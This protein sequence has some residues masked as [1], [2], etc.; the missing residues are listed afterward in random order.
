MTRV[1]GIDLSLTGTGMCRIVTGSHPILVQTITFATK[2]ADT[3]TLGSRGDRLATIV[4]LVFGLGWHWE[5]DLVTVEGP[6]LGKPSPHTWDRAGLWW[7]VMEALRHVVPVVEIPPTTLKKFATGNGGAGK[8]EVAACMARLWPD[9]NARND[10]EWDALALAHAAA[11]HLGA[12]VPHRA[13]H[14]P[15]LAKVQWPTA[16]TGEAAS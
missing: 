12:D 15:A 10:N 13:H 11:S 9:A 2:P 3:V 5:A 6:S 16:I 14:A 8:T 7:R 4:D 1:L